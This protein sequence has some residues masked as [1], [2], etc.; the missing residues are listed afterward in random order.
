[1][2]GQKHLQKRKKSA[3]SWRR[4]KELPKKNNSEK[5]QKKHTGKKGSQ[6]GTDKAL[7]CQTAELPP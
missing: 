5:R 6:P 3:L 4:Y 2:R 7:Q 1:M